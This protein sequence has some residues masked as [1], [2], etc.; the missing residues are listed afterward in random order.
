VRNTDL[1]EDPETMARAILPAGGF[2]IKN[3]SV[4]PV[5]HGRRLGRNVFF[6]FRS[7]RPLVTLFDHDD[8]HPTFIISII[9]FTIIIVLFF[10][11]GARNAAR[12][13]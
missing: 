11:C 7:A 2:D 6:C 9:S 5:G 8:T 4:R 13:H 1:F 3:I 10:E 12:A